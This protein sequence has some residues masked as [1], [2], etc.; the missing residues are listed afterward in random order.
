MMLRVDDF[1]EKVKEAPLAVAFSFCKTSAGALFAISARVDSEALG[2][3]LR[4]KFPQFP[5]LKYPVAEWIASLDLK[6]DVDLIDDALSRDRIHMVLARNSDSSETVFSDSGEVK[7]VFPQAVCDIVVQFDPA[8]ASCLRAEWSALLAQHDAVPSSKRDFNQAQRELAGAL[9]ADKDPV[10][11]LPCPRMEPARTAPPARVVD[12]API[13]STGAARRS[14]GVNN[15]TVGLLWCVGGSL[16]TGVT[17][18]MAVSSGGGSYV[19]AW[20]AIVFGGLQ[21][22]KGLAQWL[23]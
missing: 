14:A 15:M 1:V 16:V 4:G 8:I 20:G 13:P 21:F 5:P 18:N 9:P 22:L 3:A 17:Y 2:A 19:I 6:Y 11:V 23:D 12:R 7:L 10:L